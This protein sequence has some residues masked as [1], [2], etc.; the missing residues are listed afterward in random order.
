MRLFLLPHAGAGA[1]AFR[2]WADALPETVEVCPVQ[3]PGRENRLR[4]PAFDR[5]EPL[6]EALSAA[7]AP[8][9]DLPWAVFGHST[10]AM[11]GYELA[12][13]QRRSGGPMPAR[14]F[15]SGRRA[16]QLPRTEPNTWDLPEDEFIDE[17]R[18]LGGVPAEV[19]ENRELMGLVIPPLRAD[20]AVNELYAYRAEA[21]LEL[22]VTVYG[23][24]ADPRASRAELEAWGEVT[25][26]P[27]QARIFP[28]DHFYLFGGSREAVLASLS[29][30]LAESVMGG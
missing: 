6:V 3:L 30:D 11:L 18:L 12:R 4:E 22:P 24:D 16:P 21:P 2:G 27:F 1:T 8:Y 17:L 25:T 20:M 14:L 19:L 23:G 5:W 29:R 7:V 10:G 28:G 26:G 13:H 9:L 15:P